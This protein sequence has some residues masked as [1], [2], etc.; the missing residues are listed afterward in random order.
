MT[1]IIKCNKAFKNEN[2]DRVNTLLCSSNSMTFHN[3]LHD[4]FKFSKTMGSAVSFKNSNPF[5]VLEYF[6]TLNSSIG[7]NAGAHQNA[8][9]LCCLITPLYTYIV[10][11]LSSAVT[12][13]S[14]KTLI[15]HDFQG[16]TTKFHD[17][18]AWKMTCKNPVWVLLWLTLFQ[19]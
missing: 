13:L 7:T 18:Q 8:W 9:H 17:F 1:W 19:N 2:Y 15:F 10:P 3:F 5:L 14:H 12:N 16:P 6:L 11:A 4:L